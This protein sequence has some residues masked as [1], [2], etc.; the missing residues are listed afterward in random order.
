VLE[1]LHVLARR[2]LEGRLNQ[3]R[4]M[5]IGVRRLGAPCACGRRIIAQSTGVSVSATTPEITIDEAIV[6]ENWR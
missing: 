4:K 5:R 3:S 2:E 6:M 1:E